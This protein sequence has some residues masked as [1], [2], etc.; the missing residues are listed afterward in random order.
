M[1]TGNEY[2]GMISS[3][4]SMGFERDQ[5][6]MALEASYNNP[7]R[8]IEYLCNVS[9][10]SLFFFCCWMSFLLNLLLA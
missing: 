7:E 10:S 6:V 2:E 9:H 3:I 1:V 4:C 5:V 8:A